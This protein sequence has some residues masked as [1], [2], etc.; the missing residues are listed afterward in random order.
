MTGRRKSFTAVLAALCIARTLISVAANDPAGP[1]TS[2]LQ[3]IGAGHLPNAYR[4]TAKVISGGL[5]EGDAAF[6]ELASLGVRTIISV[7]GMTPDV[8]TAKK[9]GL[10]YVHLPHGYDRIPVERGHELAKAVRDLPGTVYIHCH[11]GKHRSPAAAA[12]ACIEAG[13]ISPESGEAVLKTAGTSPNYRGL[14]ESVRHARPLGV[15]ELTRLKVEFRETSPVPPLAEAMVELEHAFDRIKRHGE[16]GWKK[17][18]DNRAAALLLL[19]H[20]KEMQRM[21]DVRHRPDRFRALL[22]DGEQTTED[23]QT[24][25]AGEPVDSKRAEAVLKKLA[26][27]CAD[28]HREFRDTVP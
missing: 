20:Y 28:C 14:Y 9:H 25:L 16:G 23:L 21:D 22:N 8:A 19:E 2:P 10:R 12:I 3:P 15:E 7:D 27:G 6:R 11:H 5:P 17:R 1:K 4:I 13:F 18:D 24:A 26:T